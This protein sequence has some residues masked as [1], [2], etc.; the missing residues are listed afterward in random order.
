MLVLI[1]GLP[2][3]GKTT[4]ARAFTKEYEA[5]HLSSDAIRKELGL[6][7]NYS[8]EAK[9]QVY[10]ILFDRAEKLLAENTTVL[11][12][13]TLYKQSLRE[14]YKDLAS[15]L[16]VPLCW[17]E[18]TISDETARKRTSKKRADSEADFAVY[19][20]IK[21]QYEAIEEEHLVLDSELGL[22]LLVQNLKQYLE[23][24]DARTS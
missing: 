11:I 8:P 2:G 21:E 15:K 17:V 16:Q 6:L 5:V 14:A 9:Q 13:S 18:L 23:A 7:G 22:D 4:L 24:Y 3:S 20:K 1:S 10:D 12:D 19:L